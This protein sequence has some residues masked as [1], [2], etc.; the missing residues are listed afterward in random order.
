MSCTYHPKSALRSGSR[1]GLALLLTLAA[2]AGAS[3]QERDS[4]KLTSAEV[5]AQT[6]A[7][8]WRDVSAE[9]LLIMTVAGYEIVIEL[10][11]TFAPQHIENLRTLVTQGYFDGLA[12]VRS[13]DNYVVQWGDPAATPEQA[14]SLGAAKERLDGEYE[15]VSR[16]IEMTSLDAVDAYADK[17]GF[18]DGFPVAADRRHTWLTHCYAMVGVGRGNEADSGNA[19]SLYVVTGHAPRHLDRNVTLIGRVLDN[20]EGLSSMPRGSGPLGFYESPDQPIRIDSIVLASSLPEDERPRWQ[21]LRTDTPTFTALVESRRTRH[22]EWFLN[23]VGRIGLCNVPLPARRA[24]A[25]AE[26]DE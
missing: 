23:E 19:S 12:I 2:S 16:D 8:D 9:N 11:P 26:D 20:V 14:R 5:L 7:D 18:V 24:P 6:T 1:V 3:A 10:A 13:Q 22:E 25:T 17:V 15:Q 21:R 4:D